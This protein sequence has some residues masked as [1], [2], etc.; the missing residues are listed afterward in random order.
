VQR[1]PDNI[2]ASSFLSDDVHPIVPAA[3]AV[4]S[5]MKVSIRGAAAPPNQLPFDL[6]VPM[7]LRERPSGYIDNFADN[8]LFCAARA[9]HGVP[10]AAVA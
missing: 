8:V 7:I 4:G 10:H 9:F 3:G 2:G 5:S 1:A 6:I